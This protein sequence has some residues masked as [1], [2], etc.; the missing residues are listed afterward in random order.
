[1]EPGPLPP[2]ERS[3]R[4]PSELAAE[5]R[6]LL[7]NESAAPSTR[8]VALTTGTIGL[9]AVAV[10]V[11]TVTP[12]RNE[13]PVA[14]S[15]TTAAASG[16]PVGEVDRS[17]DRPPVI[18]AAE[19]PSAAAMAARPTPA[20]PV[21]AIATPVADGRYAIVTLAAATGAG[22]RE[23]RVR[24]PS[25][26]VATATIAAFAGD[27]AI[28]TLDAAEPGH[29]IA[30]RP[31]DDNAVVTV[32]ATP[33]VTIAYGD[34]ATLDLVEGTPVIDGE[35]EL[36][37]LCGHDRRDGSL[38]VIDVTEQLADATSDGR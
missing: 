9:A 14:I 35:G 11:L 12:H 28:V 38:R 2:Y 19:A 18:D 17:E 30:D 5:E 15:V 34:V 13:A 36:V 4:H 6:A 1:M 3:W 23:L 10:L 26:R 25:G 37:G 8:A 31:P 20:Q 22:R 16:E 7:T 24:L 21:D 29:R 32:M 33:S 27:V